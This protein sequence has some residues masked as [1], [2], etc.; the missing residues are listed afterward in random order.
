M[1]G[2]IAEVVDEK[3]VSPQSICLGRIAVGAVAGALNAVGGGEMIVRKFPGFSA[4]IGKVGKWTIDRI[5][6]RIPALAAILASLL[7]AIVNGIN[8][9]RR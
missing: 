9:R 1:V 7:S 3:W 8:S 2:A 5:G 4:A 6:S